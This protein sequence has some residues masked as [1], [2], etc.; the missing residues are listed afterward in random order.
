MWKWPTKVLHSSFVTIRV[1][2]AINGSQTYRRK[3]IFQ[4]VGIKVLFSRLVLAIFDPLNASFGSLVGCNTMS[5][6]II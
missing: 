4:S 5:L 1:P 6:S 3:V 2:N